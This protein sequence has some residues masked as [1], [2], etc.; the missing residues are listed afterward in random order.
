MSWLKRVQQ[1]V[2]PFLGAVSAAKGDSRRILF[3]ALLTAAVAVSSALATA[4]TA[5]TTRITMFTLVAALLGGVVAFC[6]A[7]LANWKDDC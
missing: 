7:V 5:D 6:Q 3:S 1:R 4:L 2:R